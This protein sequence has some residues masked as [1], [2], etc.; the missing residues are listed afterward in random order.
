MRSISKKTCD[1]FI[2]L[3][4]SIRQDGNKWL[5]RCV[6]LSTSTFGNTFEETREALKEAVLLHLNT[7]EDV[8]ECERFLKENHVKVYVNVP[9]PSSLRVSVKPGVFVTKNITPI[10]ALQAC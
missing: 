4:F 10:S 6:E 1:R 9:H 7:L 2:V 8:G 3:T 5:A